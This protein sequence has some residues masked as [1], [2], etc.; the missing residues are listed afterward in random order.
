MVRQEEHFRGPIYVDEDLYNI[1]AVDATASRETQ[2]KEKL[3]RKYVYSV[4]KSN[5]G[6]ACL[7]ELS[8]T[9]VIPC[10]SLSLCQDCG[11]KLSRHPVRNE[12][13]PYL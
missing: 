12:E 3:D 9:A 4:D 6:V 7:T 11:A 2:K 13:L 8:N 5:E 10:V 1:G